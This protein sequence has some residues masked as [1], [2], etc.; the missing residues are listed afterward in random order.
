[1]CRTLI[2]PIHT[3][4]YGQHNTTCHCLVV[5]LLLHRENKLGRDNDEK[6]SKRMKGCWRAPFPHLLPNLLL[7][8]SCQSPDRGT[9]PKG[10]PRK[11]KSSKIKVSPRAF[12]VT[13][14]LTRTTTRVYKSEKKKRKRGSSISF[15]HSICGM[16]VFYSFYL[17]GMQYKI[18]IPHSLV[19]ILRMLRQDRNIPEL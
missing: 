2:F 3:T 5:F 15:V 11:M 13:R 10:G 14:C 19:V 17:M 7:P 6:K 18:E 9:C 1:M 12:A 16:Y 8:Y 4:L